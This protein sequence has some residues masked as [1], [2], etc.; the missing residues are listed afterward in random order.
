MLSEMEIVKMLD[1]ANE[2]LSL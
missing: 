2:P 1:R